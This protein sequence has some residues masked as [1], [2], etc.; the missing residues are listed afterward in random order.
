VVDRLEALAV[1][2][3]R[4]GRGGTLAELKA[5]PARVSLASLLVEID[6]LGRARALGLPDDLFAGV[7]DVTVEA[8]RARAALEYPSDLRDRS[9]PVRLALL[10]A[11][12]W[13]RTTEL[14]DGLVDLLLAIVLKISTR[15]ERRV[16]G[17]LVSDLKRV[18]GK[19]GILFRLAEA[20]VEHPDDTVRAAL[21]PV[22]GE[23]TLRELAREAKANQSAFRARVRVVLRSS[24]SNH[25][26]RLLGPLLDAV[27]VRSNN[28]THR[29]VVDA[30]ALLRR[31]TGRAGQVYDAGERVPL[32][33]VVPA[34]WRGAVVDDAGRVERVPYE[35]C[36]LG[37]LRDGLR[38]RELW[39]VGSQRWRNPED[40]LPADFE[41][42]REVHYGAL[43]QPLDAGS[44]IAELKGRMRDAYG[45]LGNA[46]GDGTCGGV[47]FTTRH[48]E[49]W[50]SV[51][52]LEK[53]PE[54]PTLRRLKQAV[55]DRWGTVDLLDV[56]KEADLRIGITDEFTSVASRE[57]IPRPELRRRLLLVLFALGTNMGIKQ[58]AAG[59]HGHGETEAALRHVRRLFV[60]RDSLRRAIVAVAN[61][62]FAERD[63]DL[64]GD[65][66]ACASDSKK[67][68]AWSSNLMTEYHV[69]YRGPGVMVYWHVERRRVCIYSQLKA[70]S[71]SE[72][73]AM[74]EGVLHHCTDAEIDRNYVDTHGQS[75]VGFAFCHLLGFELLPR[76]KNIGTQRLYLPAA[77]GSLPAALAP[78]ATRPIRWDLIAQQYDQMV[79][80]A[81]A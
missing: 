60:N 45:R 47:R 31:Y 17:E 63:R 74:I 2:D 1:D 27:D 55:V 5:D 56:L 8:W 33:G 35:L 53:L 14:T 52:K 34:E 49:P 3:G 66:T 77:D 36:V 54:P 72:V 26:R 29:P 40:D 48:G 46:L 38:R 19:E 21:Y 11:L 42:H 9:R 73:A 61:A 57:V 65:G 75:A 51:P 10:A 12:C 23:A 59:D 67:F 18:R 7:P 24:Y 16:E 64:W 6:K 80:Y 43:R 25:Y 62:T 22:V 28:T 76:L 79:K 58:I 81:T 44:F 20:A 15:A 50:V 78:V 71:S 70:C 32:N 13:T 69:R 30:L 4:N 37:A 41:L 68:G 39:V